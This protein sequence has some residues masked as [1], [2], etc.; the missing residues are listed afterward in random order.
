MI[1]PQLEAALEHKL[2]SFAHPIVEIADAVQHLVP[3]L[4]DVPGVVAFL[5][6]PIA[7]GGLVVVAVVVNELGHGER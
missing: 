3:K 1:L 7:A 6:T 2:I 4:H 5:A